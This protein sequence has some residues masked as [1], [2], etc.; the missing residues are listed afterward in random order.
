M[1][2][3]LLILAMAVLGFANAL[4]AAA[5]IFSSTPIGVIGFGTQASA[6]RIASGAAL[7]SISTSYIDFKSTKY[8]TIDV[9]CQV[10]ATPDIIALGVNDFGIT[11]N[12][13]N[14]FVGGVNEC[15]IS[16]AL[17]YNHWGYIKHVANIG[18]FDTAGQVFLGTTTVNVGMTA[19]PDFTQNLYSI[20]ILMT[21]QTGATCNP[22]VQAAFV[23][24]V[25]L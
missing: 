3:K 2:I 7:A 16:T 22:Q 1:K 13:Q 10:P 25:I 14:G 8:G 24:E 12:N 21:R 4:P 15:E 11:F 17:V 19:V 18:F 9:V 5:Q 6:C 20:N 23:N